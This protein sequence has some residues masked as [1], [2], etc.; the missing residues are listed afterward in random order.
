MKPSIAIA[1][2]V[3]GILLIASP[4]VADYFWRADTM[5]I[6][7]QRPDVTSL[8]LESQIGEYKYGCF[9]AG[10]FCLGFAIRYSIGRSA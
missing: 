8:N 9:V 10:I 3:A 5:R 1:L 2:I 4:L 7:L 6:L